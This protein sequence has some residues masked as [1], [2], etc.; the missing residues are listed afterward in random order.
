[1]KLGVVS[2]AFPPDWTLEQRFAK[3]K[4]LGLDGVQLGMDTTGDVRID[5]TKEEMLAIRA[6]AE[7]YGLEIPCI[8][9]QLCWSHTMSSGILPAVHPDRSCR[10]RS[11]RFG[12]NHYF[13][14]GSST[15]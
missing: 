10:K 7:K 4:E 12:R 3:A 11:S 14:M 2:A 8:M 6:L 1:M 9:S 13:L 5:S 15:I